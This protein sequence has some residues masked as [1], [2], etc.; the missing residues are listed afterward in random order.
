MPS[1][2]FHDFVLVPIKEFVA[3]LMSKYQ[4]KEWGGFMKKKPTTSWVVLS[5]IEHRPEQTLTVFLPINI[6]VLPS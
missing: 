6:G 3:T 5:I 2:R 1:T 4:A